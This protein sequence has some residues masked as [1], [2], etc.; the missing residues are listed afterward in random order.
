MLQTESP[1]QLV[2]L[3][4]VVIRPNSVRLTSNI[5]LVGRNG[6]L[7]PLVTKRAGRRDGF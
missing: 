1:R 4:G 7:C 6:K 5:V 3:L 2:F